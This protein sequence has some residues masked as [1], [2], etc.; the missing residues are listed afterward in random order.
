MAGEEPE[1]L[2]IF[3]KGEGEQGLTTD[4]QVIVTHSCFNTVE[5]EGLGSLLGRDLGKTKLHSPVL[6]GARAEA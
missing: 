5:A 2:T 3:F 4:H 1:R 6:T